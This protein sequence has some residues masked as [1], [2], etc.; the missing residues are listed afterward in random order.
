MTDWSS[1]KTISTP[2]TITIRYT[3][4]AGVQASVALTSTDT[5]ETVTTFGVFRYLDA[6]GDIQETDVALRK[7]ETKR[8]TLASV[9][10][11]LVTDRLSRGLG[12]P[13]G[14]AITKSTTEYVYKVTTEGPELLKETTKVEITLAEFAGG[15]NVPSYKDY[16]PGTSLIVSTEREQKYDS[17]LSA[18]G[19]ETTRTITSTWIAYGLTQDGQQAFARQMEQTQQF[20]ADP[21]SGGA[22]IAASV[23][24]MTPLMFQGSEVQFSIGRAPVPS[25]A[26]NQSISRTE[27]T[28][29]N[30][31][32]RRFKGSISFSDTPNGVVATVANYTMPFSPDDMFEYG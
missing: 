14:D 25:K 20:A 21:V 16:A 11:A 13:S 28:M 8:T 24:S 6:A 5:S 27:V 10:G 15:L 17:S 32:Q 29:G 30:G 22:Y 19:R 31:D 3:N 18:D 2:R 12:L 26:S 1:S 4:T 23:N 9:N 7:V